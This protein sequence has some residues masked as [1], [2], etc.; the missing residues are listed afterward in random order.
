MR[1]TPGARITGTSLSMV[2]V[3]LDGNVNNFD[4]ATGLKTLRKRVSA[5]LIATF[6]YHSIR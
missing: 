3:S 1:M 6:T 4:G 5:I 2:A